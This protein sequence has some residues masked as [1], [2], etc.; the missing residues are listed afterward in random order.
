MK[1]LSASITEMQADE[2]NMQ[3]EASVHGGFDCKAGVW[4][5]VVLTGLD[6]FPNAGNGS[7]PRGGSPAIEESVG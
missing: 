2:G 6:P 5:F 1:N 4:A 3:V 7:S